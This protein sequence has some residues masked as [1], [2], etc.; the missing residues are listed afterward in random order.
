MSVARLGERRSDVRAFL[1]GDAG[2]L[3]IPSGVADAVMALWLAEHLH[4]P[5]AFFREVAR[6]LR[7]G[8]GMIMLTPNRLNY[9]GF[10]TSLLPRAA[11][12][13]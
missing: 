12:R 11:K 7:P 1:L 10:V 4:S 5:P 8:G 13:G 6:I 9:C 2:H 3:P